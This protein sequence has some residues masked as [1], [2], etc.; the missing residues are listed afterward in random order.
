MTTRD[1][2]ADVALGMMRRIGLDSEGREIVTWLVR[3]HLLMAEVAT[4]RDLSDASV[5]D[6]LAADVRGRRRTAA[7]ALPAH[8]RRLARDRPRG[9]GRDEGRARCATCSSRPRPRSSGVRPPPS[10]TTGASADRAARRGDRGGAARRAC[11]RR[12]SSRS[13]STTSSSTTKLLAAA[14][15]VRLP[16]PTATGSRSRSSSPDRPRL[17]ATLA[18]A[19]TVCGLDV[20]EANLFGTTDGLALDVFRAA[21]PFGRVD[22]GGAA[23]ERHDPSRAR[24]AR[25]TSRLASPIAAATIAG[26]RRDAVRPR[27]TSRSTSPRPTPSSRCTPTTRSDCCTGLPRRSPTSASTCGSPKSRTLGAR[28][29]DVFYVRDRERAKIEDPDALEHLRDALVDAP[30]SLGCG[31]MDAE[32]RSRSRP[33]TCCAGPRRSPASRAPGSGSRRASTSRS[34]SRRC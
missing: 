11:P 28:V 14:P 18:G 32:R 30:E 29:V 33:P 13:T 31:A 26:P 34:A 24:Q 2:G 19:L 7:P 15:A 21:D 27:S 4:R 1:V 23:V 9:V 8:D 10:P 25:S 17:L 3:N 12:T 6:N 22:D 5:A 20:L 16:A